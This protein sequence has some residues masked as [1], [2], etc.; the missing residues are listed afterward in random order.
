[1]NIFASEEDCADVYRYILV[2]QVSLLF[3]EESRWATVIT[4]GLHLSGLSDQRG[5]RNIDLVCAV[6]ARVVLVLEGWV[7]NNHREDGGTDIFGSGLREDSQSSGALIR[8][9]SV[10]TEAID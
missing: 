9:R 7:S 3:S 4:L 6:A 2:F 1:M 8:Y 10:N 5:C